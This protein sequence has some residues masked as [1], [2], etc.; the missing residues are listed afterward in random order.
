MERT[1]PHAVPRQSGSGCL[2]RPTRE[3]VPWFRRI[4]QP[5][6]HRG[7][8]NRD[9]LLDARWKHQPSATSIFKH[10]GHVIWFPYYRHRP[11][12][13]DWAY[14]T[15]TTSIQHIDLP[16]FESP[17]FPSSLVRSLSCN[18]LTGCRSFK[19]SG[20]EGKTKRTSRSA[21]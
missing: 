8:R 3:C 13:V 5:R 11:Q 16:T 7:S 4:V 10:R 1:L 19:Y 20:Q 12:R 9:R 21:P 15:T 2:L 14:K 6:N 17:L 18:R